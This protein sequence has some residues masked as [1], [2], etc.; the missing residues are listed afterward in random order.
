MAMSEITYQRIAG[1]DMTESMLEEAS[2]LFSDHYGVWGVAARPLT[3][4]GLYND[5]ST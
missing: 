3:T 4:P 1:P 5:T 2:A